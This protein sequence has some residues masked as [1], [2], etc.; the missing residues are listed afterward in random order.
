VAGKIPVVGK[1]A[2][3]FFELEAAVIDLPN[4]F[5]RLARELLIVNFQLA[6]FSGAMAEVKAESDIREIERKQRM[7]EALAPSAQKL[8]EAQ[9]NLEDALEPITTAFQQ[10]QN[11]QL[12]WLTQKWADLMNNFG[13][14]AAA[15]GLIEKKLSLE[16]DRTSLMQ[17]A[18]QNV[19]S[20]WDAKSGRP[21]RFPSPRDTGFSGGVGGDF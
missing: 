3:E 12:A 15:I 1:L 21:N 5:R 6:E 9:Q 18:L 19:L 8:A 4:T 16:K 11:E 20:A 13:D 14:I 10:K 17:G 7:G 2:Q